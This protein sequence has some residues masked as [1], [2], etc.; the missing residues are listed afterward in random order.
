[1]AKKNRKNKPNFFAYFREIFTENPQW[2]DQRSNAD[3][4]ARYRQDH[5]VA[6]DE[7]VAKH[8]KEALANTKT[9]LRKQV[10]NGESLTAVTGKPAKR[11]RKPGTTASTASAGAPVKRMEQLEEQIDDCMLAAMNLDRT[12]L[13]SVIRHLR[14]ARKE[15]ILITSSK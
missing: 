14:R 4:Y 3:V 1:M 13:D 10:K 15:I 12:G 7:P 2:L 5:N 6:E 9:Q 8:V 11:G